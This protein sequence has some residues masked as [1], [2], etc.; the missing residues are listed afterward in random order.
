VSE[1]VKRVNLRFTPQYFDK[2][3]EARFRSRLSFQELGARLFGNWLAGDADVPLHSS[4]R[5]P[6]DPLLEKLAMIQ[7][8]GDKEMLALVQKAIEVT[9]LVMQQCVTPEELAHLKAVAYGEAEPAPEP[10]DT[11]RAP[12]KAP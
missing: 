9:Y 7:A 4:L 1:N 12:K 11:G 10:Q 2:L 8:R 6:A 3:D 5:E